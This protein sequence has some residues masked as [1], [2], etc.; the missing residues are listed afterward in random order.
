M[1]AKDLGDM[2]P[3]LI[4]GND[5]KLLSSVTWREWAGG[6]AV[7]KKD[8]GAAL[9]VSLLVTHAEPSAPMLTATSPCLAMPSLPPTIPCRL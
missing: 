2:R 1:V 5:T 7:N 3:F 8:R 6:D 4:F 9:H